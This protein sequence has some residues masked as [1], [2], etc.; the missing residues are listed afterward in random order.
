ML[1]CYR[2][3][4]EKLE[5]PSE[6]L[7]WVIVE[8]DSEDDTASILAKWRDVEVITCNTGIGRR[9]S[10]VDAE[11]FRGLSIV[12]NACI[13][14]VDLEWSDYMLMWPVD[15]TVE[16]SLLRRL[17]AHKK[18]MIAPFVWIHYFGAWRFYDTWAFRANGRGF[19]PF[20]MDRKYES[21]MRMES[22]GGVNL[23]SSDVLKA[24][25]RYTVTEVDRGL[26]AMAIDR[27]FGVWSDPE[28]W[29]YHPGRDVDSA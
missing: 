19:Q 10:I 5:W 17:V 7:R 24:G 12:S 18:D 26:C 1:K 14:A 6:Q 16:P 29:V 20:T 11:R 8:G 21:P 3:Q 22:V 25:C 13:D 15:I 9:G 4:I 2:A 23:I 27:G 28:T